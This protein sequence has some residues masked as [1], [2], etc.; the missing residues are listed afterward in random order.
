MEVIYHVLDV[1]ENSNI[2]HSIYPKKI[3]REFF[4]KTFSLG[5]SKFQIRMFY[6]RI[7]ELFF[8]KSSENVLYRIFMQIQHMINLFHITFVYNRIPRVLGPS[9]EKPNRHIIW[10]IWI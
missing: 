3:A 2:K 8:E 9:S 10:L 4:Y 1:H 6:N 7:R 5:F